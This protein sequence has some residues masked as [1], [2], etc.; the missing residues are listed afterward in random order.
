MH[1]SEGGFISTRCVNT[2]FGEMYCLL[3]SSLD[4][5]GIVLEIKDLTAIKFPVFYMNIL[6][7]GDGSIIS[8]YPVLK[9]HIDITRYQKESLSLLKK[10]LWYTTFQFIWVASELRTYTITKCGFDFRPV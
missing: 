6:P 7:R 4:I 10:V 9:K 5:D 3:Q 8:L 2:T 1:R